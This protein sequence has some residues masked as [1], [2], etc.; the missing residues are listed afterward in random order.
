MAIDSK[1]LLVWVKSMSRGQALPLD[2][3]EIFNTLAE[4]ET[5]ALT[6]AIAYPGQTIKVLQEDGKYHSYVLQPSDTGYAL[7]EIEAGGGVT[8]WDDLTDKPFGDLPPAFDIQWDGDM[9]GRETVELEPGVYY[10]KVGDEAYTKEQ[11]VGSTYGVDEY[12]VVTLR[13]DYFVD[14][15][16]VVAFENA[17]FIY[18]VDDLIAATG[19]PEGSFS[20]GV[21]FFYSPESYFSRFTI[22]AFDIKWDG[23][24]TDREL[25][26]VDTGMYF[27]KVSDEVF[28]KD[29]LAGKTVGLGYCEIFSITEDNVTE[30]PGGCVVGPGDIVSVWSADEFAAANGIPDGLVSNGIGFVSAYDEYHCSRLTAPVEVVKIDPK[31]LP[32]VDVDSLGLAPVAVSGSYNDLTDKPFGEEI[33]TKSF[34]E[35]TDAEFT[36]GVVFPYQWSLVSDAIVN[37]GCFDE[38][39]T[40][41]ILID[42]ESYECICVKVLG[43]LNGMEY[44]EY[45]LQ[46]VGEHSVRVDHDATLGKYTVYAPVSDGVHS[47]AIY[48][49][50][51][52]TIK[53]LD[54]KYLPDSVGKVKTVNGQSPDENGNV[55][56]ETGGVTSWNDLEDKPFGD[57]PNSWTETAMLSIDS[58]TQADDGSYIATVPLTFK[59]KNGVMYRIDLIDKMWNYTAISHECVCVVGYDWVD[60]S[61]TY[62]LGVSG[63]PVYMSARCPATEEPTSWNFVFSKAI[64]SYGYNVYINEAVPTIIPLDEKYIP[65]TIARVKDIPEIPDAV[66]SVNGVTPDEN[67][68]VKIETGGVISWNDLE[69]KP[70]YENKVTEIFVVEN[71]RVEADQISFKC[72][73]L[74]VG[75]R[76]RLDITG[77]SPLINIEYTTSA[78]ATADSSN[79]FTDFSISG[80]NCA[81]LFGYTYIAFPNTMGLTSVTLRIFDLDIELKTLD[82]KFIPDTIA[83]KTDIPEIPTMEEIVEEV[84]E[85]LPEQPSGGVTS[86]NDLQDKPFR[87]EPEFNIQWD[88]DMTGRIAIDLSMFGYEQGMYQVKISDDVLT[89]D[90][91]IGCKYVRTTYGGDAFEYEIDSNLINTES[92]PGA[93]SINNYIFIIHDDKTLATALGIPAGIYT[94]GVYFYLKTESMYISSLV[95]ANT[96]TKVDNEHLDMDSIIT[97]VLN[98]LPIYNGEVES[99]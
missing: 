33:V 16:G 90:K 52:K 81:L 96:I 35:S 28:I 22:D 85:Q 56:V 12:F 67:G 62:S 14:G 84:L 27:V 91:L 58:A 21:W 65:D 5:Y 54:E 69:D 25:I 74:K 93:I 19:M 1:N 94:N 89:T 53:P 29:Q 40:Y 59:P 6:S 2:S 11:L 50:V 48:E 41:Y 42:G 47:V 70:F 9:T 97:E 72:P 46:P 68:N 30:V 13:E 44:N 82:E 64:S 43:S 20:N 24:I 36:N 88:G 77:Y 32:E 95:S 38:G 76:Y 31:Y 7:G 39:K 66:L 60:L 23:D 49:V 80:W 37:A 92:F 87:E 26:E 57:G 17:L 73:E 45:D 75:T 18:S 4:A 15:P 98:A 86:W 99:V 79:S 3:S 71:C 78:M 63:D 51:S 55:E 34:V 83:R 10:A 61:F 8:S